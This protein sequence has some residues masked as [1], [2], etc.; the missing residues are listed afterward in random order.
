MGALIFYT[1]IYFFGHFS[2]YGL[3]TLTNRK[4][5]NHRWTGLTGVFLVATLHGYRIISSTPPSGHDDGT[6][7][8]LGYYVIFPVGVISA[9]FFYLNGKNNSDDDN[10]SST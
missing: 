7:Y 3:N 2:A 9:I 5:L 6:M 8:A 4:L 10:D 1:F